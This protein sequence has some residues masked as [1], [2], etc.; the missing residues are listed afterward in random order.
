MVDKN[1]MVEKDIHAR[2]IR[3]DKNMF[4]LVDHKQQM[5][6]KSNLK[7]EYYKTSTIW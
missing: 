6:K 2:I 7:S 4:V 3:I 1:N 5:L